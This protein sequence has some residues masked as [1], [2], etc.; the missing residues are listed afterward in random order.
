MDLISWNL[1]LQL[2]N[3][4]LLWRS[5]RSCPTNTFGLDPQLPPINCHELLLCS[6]QT[7]QACI[8]NSY[9]GFPPCTLPAMALDPGPSVS[10]SSGPSGHPASPPVQHLPIDKVFPIQIGSEVFRISYLSTSPLIQRQRPKLRFT[11]LLYPILHHE[12]RAE[13]QDF[14]H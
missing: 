12:Q 13:P 9:T 6:L 2:L 7:Y 10:S 5:E 8:L 14:I 11:K 1:R 3:I 4:S